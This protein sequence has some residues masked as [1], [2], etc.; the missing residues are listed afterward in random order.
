VKPLAWGVAMALVASSPC[1]R[2]ES[3]Y[4]TASDRIESYGL[5]DPYTFIAP[6]FTR[7]QTTLWISITKSAVSAGGSQNQGQNSA[8]KTNAPSILFAAWNKVSDKAGTIRYAVTCDLTGVLQ[9]GDP[10]SIS[11][12][13]PDN[14]Y[15]GSKVVDHITPGNVFVKADPAKPASDA[16]VTSTATL[17]AA[18][19]PQGGDATVTFGVTTTPKARAYLYLLKNSLYSDAINVSLDSNG[20]LS[21]SDSSSVQQITGILTELAQ[22]AQQLA[23]GAAKL[24][25]KEKKEAPPPFD[26][27]LK[28]F[29]AIANLIK[30]GPYYA[31]HEFRT[32]WS[33]PLPSD[34]DVSLEFKLQ[35]LAGRTMQQDLLPW[36]QVYDRGRAKWL[37]AQNGL[38]AFFPVPATA[39]L[40]CRATSPDGKK[41]DPIFLSAPSNIN[42]YTASQFVDPQRDLFTGPQDT[43]TFSAGVITGHKYSGQSPAKTL[44]DMITSP[45]RALFPTVSIQQSVQVQT[46]GG[47]PDQTTTQ[48]QTS[49]GASKSQ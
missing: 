18:C 11:G 31:E 4:L 24:A 36:R 13:S 42:L 45:V 8:T 44:V 17:N 33:Q 29:A 49:I 32:S 22:T 34:K 16:T 7:V 26:P 40:A 48:T 5:G 23:L 3:L 46:G 9:D 41:A 28:C 20:M 12:V 25:D 47:K 6:Y 14:I 1:A 37:Y 35:P 10:I 39:T 38:L 2:A 27:R 19:Q 30:T 21:I 15:S 43:F